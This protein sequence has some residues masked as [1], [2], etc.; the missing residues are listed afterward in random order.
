M[1]R[2]L[3]EALQRARGARPQF[4]SDPLIDHLFAVSVGLATEL[5]V[6]RQRL[7]TLERVLER[8]GKLDRARI[9]SYEPTP[10]E[11]AERG[12]QV[13]QL[14]AVAFRTLLE[15]PAASTGPAGAEEAQS[16][17]SPAE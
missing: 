15:T 17:S 16:K 2:V 13:S 7:D 9:E 8:S 11:A 3:E 14:L 6:T 1:D 10:E 4:T 12:A 5:A